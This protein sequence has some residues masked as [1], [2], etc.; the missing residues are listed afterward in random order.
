MSTK[1]KISDNLK[2]LDEIINRLKSLNENIKH[3]Y[4][5]LNEMKAIAKCTL[6]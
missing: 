5:S 2:K 4:G 1:E 3:N 6:G